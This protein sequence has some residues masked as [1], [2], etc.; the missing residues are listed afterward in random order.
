MPPVSAPAAPGRVF[1]DTAELERAAETMGQLLAPRQRAVEHASDALAS[2]FATSPSFGPVATAVIDLA[3][4]YVADGHLD[5][6]G[7]LATADA[8]S[9]AD[10]L[11]ADVLSGP[12]VPTDDWVEA[13]RR[14]WLEARY[15]EALNTVAPTVDATTIAYELQAVEHQLREL[16]RVG[17]NPDAAPAL[18]EYRDV[19]VAEAI[20][21]VDAIG[22]ALRAWDGTDNDPI[23]DALVAQRRRLVEVLVA[24]DAFAVEQLE[25]TVSSGR[26]AGPALADALRLAAT[27]E[28]IEEVMHI[29]GV[30]REAAIERIMAMDVEI[31]A[32]IDAGHSA[33][34]ALSA[35]ALA[36]VNDLDLDA[37][38]A[39]AA[40]SGQSPLEVLGLMLA[41]R[42]LDMSLMQFDA[43]MGLQE[44]FDA[45]DR[46]LGPG[47]GRVSVEDLAFVVANPGRFSAA[48]VDAAQAVL[49]AGS[50]FPRLDTAHGNA[51]I[52]DD[53]SFGR[54]E[55]GD[56]LIST[57]DLDAFRLATA[58][59]R[60]LAAHRRALD[61]AADGGDPDG[62]FSR[63]D[64]EAWLEDPTN[65]NVPVEARHAVEA[66]LDF[67][68]YDETM[69][70]RHRDDLAMGAA[71]VAGGTVLVFTGGGAVVVILASA[72]AAGATAMTVNAYN[73]EDLL[74]GVLANTVDGALVGIS[75][76]GLPA[77]AAGA[78]AAAPTGTPTLLVLGDLAFTANQV[79]GTA[80]VVA[81]T[82]NIVSLGGV[83]LLLPGQWEDD[84]HDVSG[85]IAVG[86]GAPVTAYDV[87]TA[88]GGAARSRVV[89][90]VTVVEGLG[91]LSDRL[92][93]EEEPDNAEGE[94]PG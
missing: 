26:P 75:L 40:D 53:D 3:R 65:D 47:D 29:E 94:T 87:A 64:L 18:V 46:A 39:I 55:L 52:L 33:D 78:T 67:E 49:D 58:L 86:V 61:T 43:Y 4:R 37:A 31:A 85:A 24:G 63:R 10:E 60:I 80:A 90:E 11:R 91:A 74:D 12:W 77:A 79:A 59:N 66:M 36:E 13:Q 71:L 69:L 23:V 44:N 93:S 81:E 70:E 50:L 22:D 5:A 38:L 62:T 20:A 68:L 9:R 25:R 92:R 42:G 35:F 6:V 76:A 54:T 27:E 28:R 89:A 7:L 83:D 15:P 16:A 82:A 8:F 72:A 48:Q 84:I 19:L 30:S 17:T 56:G 45:F 14:R 34:T 57:D 41:A 73:E 51:D 32:M 2:Y 1:A 21:S 88:A